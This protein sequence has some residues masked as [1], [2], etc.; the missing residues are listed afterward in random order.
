M[1]QDRRGEL[2]EIGQRIDWIQ[3]ARNILFRPERRSLD[4]PPEE[5]VFAGW[6]ARLNRQ[7]EHSA[8]R[9]TVLLL[10]EYS[11]GK[12]TLLNA[13]LRL[14]PGKRLLSSADPTNAKPIRLSCDY[15]GSPEARLI[16]ADKTEQDVTWDDAISQSVM[17]SQARWDRRDVIEAQVFIERPMLEFAD[18]MDMPGTGTSMHEEHTE[19]T[20]DYIAN[21][22][23]I[24]WVI[25]AEPPSR[26]GVKDFKKVCEAGVPVTVVF[27]VWGYLDPARD[28]ELGIDQDEI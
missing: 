2:K 18:F 24:L 10:G 28:A 27:N 11:A 12:S 22:E 21:A 6:I 4:L 5:I 1:E 19:I 7:R 26:E 23:M 17:Q 3:E 16:F 15:A 25:G 20:R 9:F 14:P 8:Q 13:L